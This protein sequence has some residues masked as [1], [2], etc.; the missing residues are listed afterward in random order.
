MDLGLKV[1]IFNKGLQGS[2]KVHLK[3]VLKENLLVSMTHL[4][5]FFSAP[6]KK[7]EEKKET[8]WVMDT[9]EFCLRTQL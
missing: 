7:E 1:H 4:F 8:G 9:S 2:L 3:K 5:S 6:N